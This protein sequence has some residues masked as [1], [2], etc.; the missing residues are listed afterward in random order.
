MPRENGYTYTGASGHVRM[1]AQPDYGAPGDADRDRIPPS[2][3]RNSELTL[4]QISAMSTVS[5]KANP[6][7]LH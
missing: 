6:N 4:G 1:S 7:P 5:P 2:N 3:Q